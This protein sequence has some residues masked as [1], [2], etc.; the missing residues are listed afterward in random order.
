MWKQIVIIHRQRRCFIF[1]CKRT[2]VFY[3]E[4]ILN[5]YVALV[6]SKYFRHINCIDYGLQSINDF[7]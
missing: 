5:I 1:Y 7:N 6:Y 3:K 4:N 2:E